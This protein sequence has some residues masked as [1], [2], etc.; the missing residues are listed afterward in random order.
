M[1]ESKRYIPTNSRFFNRFLKLTYGSWLK[2][3][4]GI[5][6]EGGELLRSLK[7]PYVVVGNHVTT[8]DPFILSILCPEPIYWVTSDGNMR[9]RFMRF[10]LG[11][12]GSIPKSKAIPDIQTVNWIVEV[13][14]KRKGVVGIFP[15]GQASWDGHTLPLF[16]STAKLLKLLKVPVVSATLEGAYFALPRWTW[17]RRH[18][19]VD[20]RWR[21]LIDAGEIKSLSSEEILRRLE[22]GI[23]WDEYGRQ[24][25]DRRPYRSSRRAEHVELALFMCPECETAGSLRSRGN[26]LHCGSCGST[27]ILDR[28]GYFRVAGQG[29][30]RFATIRDWSTWQVSAFAAAAEEAKRRPD[31]AFITDGGAI[32]RKGYRTNPLRRIRTGTL[33]LYPDRLELMTVLG[34][35]ISLPV[36]ELDGVGVLKRNFL[37]FYHGRNLYQVRFALRSISA[38]KWAVAIEHMAGSKS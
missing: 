16:P 26:R 10:F 6:T 11:L 24:E 32:L 13:I 36:A 34:E 23:A 19:R 17:D 7:P 29:K 9:T 2:V 14:R 12:V 15:E 35:R 21:L 18:G 31:E 38:R 28:Y 27:V 22:A 5:H 4:Y 3:A 20:V 1:P 37:E 33:S 25:G 30:A 8:R